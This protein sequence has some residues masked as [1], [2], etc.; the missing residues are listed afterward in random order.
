[1]RG[2]VWLLITSLLVV[3]TAVYALLTRP[4]D[5]S[6]E[7]TV[8]TR[9]PVKLRFTYWGTY[10]EKRA[11]ENAMSRFS[12][13]YPWI[14]V[15]AIQLPNSDYNAKLMAMSASNEEPDLGYMTNELG[16]VFAEQGKFIDLYPLIEQDPSLD[17][18]DFLD[19]LWYEN[20]ADEAWGISTAAECF[21]LFYRRDLLEQY[22]VPYPPSKAEE[23]WTWE[24]F[25]HAAQL[26][27][28]DSHGRNAL[29]PQFDPKEIVQYGVMFETWSE[30]ISNFIFSNGGQWV[31]EE[32]GEFRLNEPEAAE[33]I[34]KLADLVNVYHVA[35]SPFETK[36]MPAMHVALQAGL[37]AM[38]IDGQWI[39]LDLGHANI[40]Y[41]IGVLPKLKHS[42]TVALSGA[43]VIFRSTKHPEEAW[44]L[45]KW[46]LDPNEA[47]ELYADGLWMPTL[48][49]WYTDPVLLDRWV[50]VNPAAHPPGFVEAMVG[51][52]LDNGVPGIGY[53][54]KHREEIFPIVT[55]ELIPVWL[56]ELRAQEAL[57]EIGRKVQ[58]YFP[59]Q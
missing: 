38:I 1:M 53:Y 42:V 3:G 43:S 51:Q 12:E 10:E 7:A 31:D 21:G 6:E 57:D 54:L 9:E 34:Q 37:A 24:E 52:L 4:S 11:I 47:I 19:Y 55:D 28:I 13:R 25:V 22:G 44:Q 23:A 41:D 35:P 46:L 39:N 8:T 59:Q 16:E 45:M 18:E 17:R 33:A 50:H 15:E 26:L 56:G 58:N 36:S 49:E 20:S 14:T 27:T 48:K 30:P 5:S 29:D 40:D 2:K 32:T